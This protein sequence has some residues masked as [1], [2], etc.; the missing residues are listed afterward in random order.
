MPDASILCCGEALIDMLPGPGGSFLP[1]PGGAVFNTALAL[2]RLGARAEFFWGLSRD[3]LGDLLAGHLAAA[4]VNTAACPRVDRP[5]TLAFVHLENGQA[6]YEF[7]DTGTAGRMLTCADLPATLPEALF[8]GGISLAAEPCG[9]TMEALF[10]RAAPSRAVM[11]DPNIRPGLLRDPANYRMRLSRMLRGA[12]I[13]KLSTEDLG[14]LAPE[15]DAAV[16]A[17]LEAG[18]RLVCV[19]D[20]ARGARAHLRGATLHAPAHSVR[21][22]DTVGAGDTFNAGLLAS[23]QAAGALTKPGLAQLAPGTVQTALDLATAAA[24]ITVSRLGADPPWA[25]EL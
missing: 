22:A 6:R 11:V 2:G 18:V 24:A 25:H 17:L 14:W 9:S 23:L 19:T 5:C 4:G 8:F 15:P 20:G 21:V 12:D 1:R 3:D 10:A 13:V 7:S 16:A